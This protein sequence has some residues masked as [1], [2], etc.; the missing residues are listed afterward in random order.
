MDDPNPTVYPPANEIERLLIDDHLPTKQRKWTTFKRWKY[1]NGNE[2]LSINHN[3]MTNQRNRTSNRRQ[4]TNEN[5]RLS[6]HN[7]PPTIQRQ[8][9]IYNRRQSTDRWKKINNRH[10]NQSRSNQSTAKSQ[11]KKFSK[12]YFEVRETKGGNVCLWAIKI[13]SVFF[14][15]FSYEGIR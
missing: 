9:T 6:N 10:S 14:S 5:E 1:T 3:L 8:R 4:S 7:N 13:C 2:R 11:V 12:H 15:L